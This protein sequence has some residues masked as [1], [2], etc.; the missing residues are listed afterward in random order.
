V[1]SRPAGAPAKELRDT[2]AAAPAPRDDPKPVAA[3]AAQ[4]AAPAATTP[5]AKPAPTAAPAVSPKTEPKPAEPSGAAKPTA[6]KWGHLMGDKSVN[7][8]DLYLL[9]QCKLAATKG[10]CASARSIAA[11]IADK[12]VAMYR[13]RVMT[14][15][16]IAACLSSK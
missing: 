13:A 11:R 6:S 2:S 14:D 5:E 9:Q 3:I 7:V 8:D 10:D 16:A 1:S 4:Q 15:A 12:N